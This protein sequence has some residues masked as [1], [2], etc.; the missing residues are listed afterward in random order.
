M[1][2]W[3]QPFIITLRPYAASATPRIPLATLGLAAGEDRDGTRS[4]AVCVGVLDAPVFWVLPAGEDVEVPH[5]VASF[6]PIAWFLRYAFRLPCETGMGKVSTARG[7]SPIMTLSQLRALYRGFEIGGSGRLLPMEGLRGVA[8]ALVF[9]QHYGMQ[10][11]IYGQLTGATLPIARTFAGYGNDGVELFFVLSGYLIYGILLRKRPSFFSFM[12]R[13]AQRLYPAFL[14]ALA[15]G[16]LLDLMQPD[17]KIPSQFMG[18]LTYLS[19]NLAFLPGLLPITPLFGVN[20]SLSYEWWFYVGAT[21]LFSVCRLAALPT[22]ARVSVIV[23]IG[24]ILLGLEGVGVPDVPIR[25]L[26]LFAGMLLA[27]ADRANFRAPPAW[28]GITAVV[29]AFALL[30]TISMPVGIPSLIVACAFY[31]LCA[32][33]FGGR[34][35]LSALLSWTHLRRFGNI[36]YSYYLVHAYVVLAV[37]R[38]L[39]RL[40]HG[41]AAD[42]LFWV[43][44]M[45]TFALSY[46]AGAALFLLV[47]KPYSLEV[48]ARAATGSLIIEPP[49]R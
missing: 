24:A 33:A 42:V 43:C 10:F 18:A 26:C 35:G 4:V 22:A 21:L 19:A 47:E 32:A 27:E 30:D 46:C 1:V 25:G 28:L 15:I 16:V 20:W 17:P 45:P 14:V 31:A 34:S 7:W 37:L 40:A 44:L 8:V 48:H 29:T 5:Q 36:S 3:C 41:W 11:T 6:S 2:S 9:L 49:G 23:G 13:R 38:P 12:G 39:F